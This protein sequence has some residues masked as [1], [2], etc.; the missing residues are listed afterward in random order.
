MESTTPW[1]SD[2]RDRATLV[3]ITGMILATTFLVYLPAEIP[4]VDDWTY[5]WSVEHFLHT[6]ELRMLE[7]SAHTIRCPRFSGGLFSAS[8][9]G[10]HSSSCAYRP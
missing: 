2:R 5:A 4:I 9:L 10:S 3:G 6:G 1:R 8:C 7:W